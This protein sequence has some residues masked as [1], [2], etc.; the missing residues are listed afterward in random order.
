M[1]VPVIIMLNSAFRKQ[2]KSV[3]DIDTRMY[4]SEYTQHTQHTKN[5]DRLVYRQKI[6]MFIKTDFC[7]KSRSIGL[8][9]VFF[10]CI[11]IDP[12]FS[13]AVYAVYIHLLL[14]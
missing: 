8:T 2:N 14:Y 6:H 1:Y 13:Y 5:K 12:C 3:Y 9:Y 11:L 10:V 4:V 7:G